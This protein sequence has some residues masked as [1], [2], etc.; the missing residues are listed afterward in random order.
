MKLFLFSLK[1]LF[2]RTTQCTFKIMLLLF[3]EMKPFWFWGFKFH[4]RMRLFRCLSF[5]RSWSWRVCVWQKP[6]TVALSL[7]FPAVR[8]WSRR[9]WRCLLSRAGRRSRECFCPVRFP[10]PCLH[11]AVPIR[12]A[13]P[14][15]TFRAVVL[16]SLPRSHRSTKPYPPFI[17][18]NQLPAI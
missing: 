12:T 17:F 11:A 16:P 9:L 1:C 13:R 3:V 18:Q 10:P 4:R 14:P 15:R 5:H 2:P 6:N 8:S 7:C